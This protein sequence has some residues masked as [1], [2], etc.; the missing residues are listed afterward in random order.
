[1][2]SG[3]GH[4]TQTCSGWSGHTPNLKLEAANLF[5]AQPLPDA[6]KPAEAATNHRAVRQEKE[7]KA[8]NQ[9]GRSKILYIYVKF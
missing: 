1:M 2:K 7:I 8:S 5:I 6:T 3:K 4:K 9:K